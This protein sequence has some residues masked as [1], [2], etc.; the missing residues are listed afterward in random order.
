MSKHMPGPWHWGKDFNGLFS[1][2]PE[3]NILSFA[4]YEG[5][6]LS[7]G[8]SMEANAR[9]IAAAPDLLAALRNLE[10]SANTVD[11]C[12]T[13]HPDNFAVA[14]RD[15]REY[16]EAARAAIAKAEGTP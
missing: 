12:Y 15:L 1:N 2:D 7:F 8:E 16:A 3:K 4:K 11:F 5:M 13:R 6:W 14:L 10:V 9:L